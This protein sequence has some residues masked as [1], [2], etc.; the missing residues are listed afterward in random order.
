MATVAYSYSSLADLLEARHRTRQGK[1]AK[2]LERQGHGENNKPT[3]AACGNFTGKLWDISKNRTTPALTWHY[4]SDDCA[5]TELPVVG[6][7]PAQPVKREIEGVADE[8]EQ[9]C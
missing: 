2:N 3:M 8:N 4:L 5:L 9:Q 6:E 7:E 1:P